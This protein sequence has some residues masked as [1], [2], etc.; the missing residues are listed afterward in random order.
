MLH[1][2]ILGVIALWT[3]NKKGENWR[4]LLT[5]QTKTFFFAEHSE[6]YC[7]AV[8][9]YCLELCLFK[10]KLNINIVQKV[11]KK[12]ISMNPKDVG[13]VGCYWINSSAI[14]WFDQTFFVQTIILTCHFESTVNE[15]PPS[16][17]SWGGGGGGG[18][19]GGAI[20][21]M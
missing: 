21:K 11:I 4:K 7:K 17:T 16:C 6:F 20:C 19:R 14:D 5:N 2:L 10:V 3:R 1:I 12:Y 9:R 15:K 8:A 13:K 18:V